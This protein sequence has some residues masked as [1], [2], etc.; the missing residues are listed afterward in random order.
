MCGPSREQCEGYEEEQSNYHDYDPDLAAE[1]VRHLTH[2]E[3]G[4]KYPDA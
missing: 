2:D 1:E 3:N 4:N